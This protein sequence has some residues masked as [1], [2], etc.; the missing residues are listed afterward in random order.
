MKC[1]HCRKEDG[2]WMVTIDAPENGPSSNISLCNPCY[3][4]M[5]PEKLRSL[6]EKVHSRSLVRQMD[7]S[8]DDS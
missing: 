8:G 4:W 5:V 2:R 6:A 7:P 1:E 3:R